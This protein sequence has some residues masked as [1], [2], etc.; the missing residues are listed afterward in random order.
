MYFLS[1]G[2]AHEYLKV[3]SPFEN[4]N[5]TKVIQ[6]YLLD[7]IKRKVIYDAARYNEEYILKMK[8]VVNDFESYDE[9]D[10]K[11]L[12]N[13]VAQLTDAKSFVVDLY[14][15][16]STGDICVDVD[17]ETRLAIPN[18]I[19]FYKGLYS[20]LCSSEEKNFVYKN[21]MYY[22]SSGEYS[23]DK[24]DEN[25]IHNLK[26]EAIVVDEDSG[27]DY[28]LYGD[29]LFLEINYDIDGYLHHTDKIKAII[30]KYITDEYV[31]NFCQEMWDN[32][33]YLG[34]DYIQWSADIKTI[35]NFVD[36][37]NN[38]LNELPTEY[39]LDAS[40][41]FMDFNTFTLVLIDVED[42]KFVVRGIQY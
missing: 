19:D 32:E 39:I 3:N 37:L 7:C 1:S 9:S 36:E 13:A 26:N 6:Y 10:L 20:L 11:S 14:T 5:I 40:G 42:N 15:D 22:R 2:T 25:G 31:F 8:L 21:M 30:E 17:D 12:K 33:K 35:Q 29:N 38:A 28:E 24:I 18:E 34:L 16:G 23:F 41:E 4:D 27:I